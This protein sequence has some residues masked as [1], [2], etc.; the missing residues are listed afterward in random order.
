VLTATLLDAEMVN[1][2]LEDTLSISPATL[3]VVDEGPHGA[4]GRCRRRL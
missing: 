1:V 3:G 2:D 4:M